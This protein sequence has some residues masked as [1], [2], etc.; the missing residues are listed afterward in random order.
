MTFSFAVFP[1]CEPEKENTTSCS[2]SSSGLTLHFIYGARFVC[3]QRIS[4]S[5]EFFYQSVY[6]Y[7][8]RRVEN[9]LS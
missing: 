9:V 3:K 4:Q 1:H 2:H 7:V 8:K 5:D 6:L